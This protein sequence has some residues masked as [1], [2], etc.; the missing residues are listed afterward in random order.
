MHLFLSTKPVR[1]YA[2]I[3]KYALK[4][5]IVD[6][7]KTRA[8]GICFDDRYRSHMYNAISQ[9]FSGFD[10]QQSRQTVLRTIKSA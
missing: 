8:Y 6:V 3:S 9:I 10:F 4:S 7:L 1:K 2:L 5:Y